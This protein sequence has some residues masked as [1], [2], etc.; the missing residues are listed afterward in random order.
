[1][2]EHL[3]SMKRWIVLS[4][5]VILTA[6]SAWLYVSK[7]RIERDFAQHKQQVAQ[8]TLESEQLAR[9]VEQ[10]MQTQ[11]VR[12]ARNEEEKR[13][14]LADRVARIDTVNRGLR[15]EIQRLNA[16]AVPED[17][18]A[19]GFA[20]EARTARELLGACSI[21]YQSMA[22]SSDELRDQVKGLIDYVNS[23]LPLS[24]AVSQQ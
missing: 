12:I 5:I 17:S 15:D 6:A 3:S 13:K 16:R 2:I 14:A 24:G 19:A 22:R 8:A 23:I 4:I 20:H 18:G 9:K 7:A 11:V 10:G 1:M 21:E